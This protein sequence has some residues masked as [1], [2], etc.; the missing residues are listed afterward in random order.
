MDSSSI[1]AVFVCRKQWP[2]TATTITRVR[3]SD[4]NGLAAAMA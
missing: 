1:N 4:G 2:N 3:G